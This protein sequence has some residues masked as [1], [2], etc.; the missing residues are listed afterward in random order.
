MAP[1]G[2]EV[3]ERAPVV[4]EG[5]WVG[6]VVGVVVGIVV[7]TVVLDPTFRITGTLAVLPAGIFTAV[8]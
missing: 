5:A 7:G 4:P 2:V 8:E 1:V 6:A 3:T